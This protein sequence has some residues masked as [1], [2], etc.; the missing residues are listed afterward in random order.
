M[1]GERIRIRRTVRR[2]QPWREIPPL[3]PRDELVIRAKRIEPLRR[4]R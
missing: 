1:R 4:R 3:D 2:E